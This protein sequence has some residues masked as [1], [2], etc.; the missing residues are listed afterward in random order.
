MVVAFAAQ[1]ADAPQRQLAAGSVA[2]RRRQPAL[3][4]A[5]R[6]DEAARLRL[7]PRREVIASARAEGFAFGEGRRR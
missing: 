1:A 3:P 4:A 7:T 5:S 6:S 2:M